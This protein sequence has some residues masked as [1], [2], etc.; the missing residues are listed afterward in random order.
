M[1]LVGFVSAI[2][3]YQA[4]Y[5]NNSVSS[6][7]SLVINQLNYQ[8]YPVNPGEYFD[9]WVKVQWLGVGNPPSNE[10]FQLVPNY[11]FSLDPNV[12]SVQSFGRLT[13]DPIVMKYRVRVDDNAVQGINQL[14]LNYNAGGDTNS[15][16]TQYFD[17]QVA[18][19]QTDFDLV[20]QQSSGTDTAIAVANIGEN[21]ANSLIVRIPQQDSYALSGTNGQMVGNLNS[22][23]YSIVSF[24]VTPTSRNSSPLQVQ[25]DYTDNIG[26]RRSVIKEVQF[27]SD[28]PV[29][30]FTRTGNFTR[31]G[32]FTRASSSSGGNIFTNIWF[33]III[34]I[35]LGV[36]YFVYKNP[37]K[38]R[39][40]LT[41][42]EKHKSK[43][44]KQGED[45]PDWVIAERK[46]KK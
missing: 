8:P 45:S 35:L 40:M 24:A 42:I 23:D 33:W 2:P 29:G 27:I 22:G 26:V 4:N 46:K 1:F 12:S 34:I 5:S 41:K 25:L 37:D 14:Q 44:E 39:D 16:N 7:S 19:A 21:T 13:T 32:N 38:V 30:N 10:T 43:N 20:V 9:L 11:P 3:S 6:S 18:D 15:W 28:S 17:I 36:G 31:S